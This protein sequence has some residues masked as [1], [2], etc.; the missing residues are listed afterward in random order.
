MSAFGGIVAFSGQRRPR[1]LP[2][3]SLATRSLTCLIAPS[4]DDDAIG[5][6]LAR[7]ERTCEPS[8]RRRPFPDKLAFRQIAGGFLVQERDTFSRSPRRWTVATERQPT[9]EEWADAQ[10]A[11]GLR[12]D[13]VERDRARESGQIVGVGCGQQ[14]VSTSG[15]RSSKG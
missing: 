6:L 8:S 4:I 11:G 5:P 14:T 12:A 3:Q 2:R 1:G 9:A 10:L 13:Y 15:P 7:N